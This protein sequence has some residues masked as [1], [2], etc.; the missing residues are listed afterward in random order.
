MTLRCRAF[1]PSMSAMRFEPPTT[2]VIWY[3]EQ[4]FSLAEGVDRQ[5]IIHE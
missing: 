5:T 1:N 2:M 3:E 4:R